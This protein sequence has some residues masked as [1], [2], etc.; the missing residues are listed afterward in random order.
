MSCV[1]VR[2]E[3]QLTQNCRKVEFDAKA[4]GAA[5]LAA[6]AGCDFDKMMQEDHH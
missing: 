3:S 6:F 4:G 5:G 1:I 2:S